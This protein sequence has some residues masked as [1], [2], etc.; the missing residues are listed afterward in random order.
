MKCLEIDK[1]IIK[2]EE[3]IKELEN[4]KKSLIY[5]CVTGKREV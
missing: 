1:L 4:Y 2:K 5:E 3:L